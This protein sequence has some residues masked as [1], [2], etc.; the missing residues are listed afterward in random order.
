MHITRSKQLT[1]RMGDY[2]SFVFRAEVGITHR[3]FGVSDVALEGFTEEQLDDLAERAGAF[4]STQIDN[5][6]ADDI[7]DAVELTQDRNSFLAQAFRPQPLARTATT[8][9]RTRRTR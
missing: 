8:A 3:D 1:V 9:P 4:I 2:E 5:L 6:L 7:N